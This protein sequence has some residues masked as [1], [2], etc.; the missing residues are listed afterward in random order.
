MHGVAA[1][2]SR[3]EAAH[4]ADALEAVKAEHE[5][6][7]ARAKEKSAAAKKFV[8]VALETVANRGLRPRVRGLR[9]ATEAVAGARW[10]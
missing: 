6:A 4:V 8:E 5:I 9:E 7:Q 10:V 2:L 1:M 3:Q